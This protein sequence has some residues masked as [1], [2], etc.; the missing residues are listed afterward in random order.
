MATEKRKKT[1]RKTKKTA[2]KTRAKPKRSARAGTAEA[3]PEPRVEPGP[4]ERRRSAP[5]TEGI[6]PAE[7]QAIHVSPPPSGPRLRIRTHVAQHD[8]TR[9]EPTV[10]A[11][12]V[13]EEPVAPEPAED[14]PPPRSASAIQGTPE[15]LK[16]YEALAALLV[17]YAQAFESEMHPRMGYCLKTKVGDRERE[18]Y[19][20]SVLLQPDH[21]RYHLFLL[22]SYP[23]IE[24]SISTALQQA[25]EGQTCFQIDRYDD[26]LIDELT[27]LTQSCFERFKLEETPE[28]AA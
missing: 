13:P 5:V 12:P 18:L 2:T 7:A 14:L 8:P 19:F 28:G 25:M 20:G 4:K 15:L 16:V 17:P 27:R 23:E 9:Y 3:P 22:Y 1:A 6:G 26:A 21:V 11:E 10:P 24:A